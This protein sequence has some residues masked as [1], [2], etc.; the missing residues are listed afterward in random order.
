MYME[1]FRTVRMT[2][3]RFWARIRAPA[4]KRK[5]LKKTADFLPEVIAKLKNTLGKQKR[6]ISTTTKNPRPS[7]M[8]QLFFCGV[9]E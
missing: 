3:C 1:P 2:L 5:G 6:S 8:F 7:E 9:L 4:S